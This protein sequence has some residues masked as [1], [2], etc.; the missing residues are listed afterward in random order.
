M[1]QT[2]SLKLMIVITLVSGDSTDSEGNIDYKLIAKQERSGLLYP[3]MA[4]LARR[5]NKLIKVKS[6]L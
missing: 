2:K 3:K 6:N 1:F 4:R 5:V